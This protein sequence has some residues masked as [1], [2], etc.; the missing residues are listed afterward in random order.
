[1]KM[2]E[3]SRKTHFI[4]S[5]A[6]SELATKAAAYI[7][8]PDAKAIAAPGLTKTLSANSFAFMSRFLLLM[9]ILLFCKR[10]HLS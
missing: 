3:E 7:E 1:M 8:A 6:N 5:D 2:K 4:C 10:K 9:R